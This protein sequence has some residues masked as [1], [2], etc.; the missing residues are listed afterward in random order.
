M[1]NV[2][3]FNL[4]LMK[5]YSCSTPTFDYAESDEKLLY[6]NLFHFC[7]RFK[8][9][10]KLIKQEYL[11]SLE[12]SLK[13]KILLTTYTLENKKELCLFHFTNIASKF[14]TK[15]LTF[16]NIFI[17]RYRFDYV[18]VSV[19]RIICMM[20]SAIYQD[21][22]IAFFLMHNS[23]TQ[24]PH[25]DRLSAREPSFLHFI[26]FNDYF[27]PF[28]KLFSIQVILFKWCVIWKIVA[29]NF[30]FLLHYILSIL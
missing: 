26:L 1:K 22:F 10:H 28:I 29:L 11:W 23:H 30:T 24:I 5:F 18:K 6:T 21:I 19:E 12:F 13:F 20:R 8:T 17:N 27:I 15:K 2:P 14:A 25:I 7:S 16:F 9:L 3:S 4:Y